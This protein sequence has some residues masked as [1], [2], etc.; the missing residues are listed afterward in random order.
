VQLQLSSPPPPFG[1]RRKPPGASQLSRSSEQQKCGVQGHG[2]GRAGETYFRLSELSTGLGS[3]C[4]GS[5]ITN[6]FPGSFSPKQVVLVDV[7]VRYFALRGWLRPTYGV[8]SRNK[9]RAKDAP[10]DLGC[11]FVGRPFPSLNYVGRIT[12]LPGCY[13]YIEKVGICHQHLTSTSGLALKLPVSPRNHPF[14]YPY[15]RKRF[16]PLF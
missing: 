3:N 10:N 8:S 2:S 12:A 15:H 13:S 7:S 16:A 4:L 14:P 1:T 6:L 11:V 9:G 5:K